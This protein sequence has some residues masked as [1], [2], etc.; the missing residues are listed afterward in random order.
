MGARGLCCRLRVVSGIN[1]REV[2]GLFRGMMEKT[3]GGGVILVHT[4]GLDARPGAVAWQTVRNGWEWLSTRGKYITCNNDNDNTWLMRKEWDEG[5]ELINSYIFFV[6]IICLDSLILSLL[7]FFIFFFTLIISVFQKSVKTVSYLY[8]I[9][10]RRLDNS[11]TAAV[12]NSTV[13]VG[14]SL[15]VESEKIKKTSEERISTPITFPIRYYYHLIYNIIR[16]T[17][18]NEI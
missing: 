17:E 15:G 9:R 12:K 4:I 7:F 3:E 16:F 2:M 18:H 10:S 8:I 11:R 1:R 13:V 6:I 5:V 14:V